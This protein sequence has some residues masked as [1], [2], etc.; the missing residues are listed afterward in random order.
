M[1]E[2]EEDLSADGPD[3]LQLLVVKVL[4]HERGDRCD[5]SWLSTLLSSI[6]IGTLELFTNE[7]VDT[8]E[9]DEG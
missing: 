5:D 8:G 9:G 6:R 7:E 4:E 3:I 2:D 1:R